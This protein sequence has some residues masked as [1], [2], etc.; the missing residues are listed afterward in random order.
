MERDTHAPFPGRRETGD[1]R[2]SRNVSLSLPLSGFILCGT[3]DVTNGENSH[4]SSHFAWNIE[5]RCR[6]LRWCP[7]AW[8]NRFLSEK[9][10]SRVEVENWSVYVFINKYIFFHLFHFSWWMNNEIFL[11]FFFFRLSFFVDKLF[12]FLST[13]IKYVYV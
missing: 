6:I 12:S 1:S 8:E 10:R 3:F 13:S 4:F 11:Y 5:Y 2:T 9:R 7:F